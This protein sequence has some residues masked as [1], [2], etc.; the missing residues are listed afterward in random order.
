VRLL[1]YADPGYQLFGHGDMF[2]LLVAFHQ[3]RTA[4]EG[5]KAKG[6]SPH[7]SRKIERAAQRRHPHSSGDGD[8]LRVFYHCR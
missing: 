8:V 2:K 7:G 1:W 3:H 6:N 4:Q 5:A